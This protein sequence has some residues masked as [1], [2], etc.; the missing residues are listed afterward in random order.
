MLKNLYKFY[1]SYGVGIFFSSTILIILL[2]L[3]FNKQT[4][5]K[6]VGLFFLSVFL[7]LWEGFHG[8]APGGRY[9]LPIV[10]TFLT[11]LNSGFNYLFKNF[12]RFKNRSISVIILL[13]LI[14]NL[15]VLE[16]RNTNLTSYLNQSV[17]KEV[18]INKLVI[19]NNKIIKENTP[20]E[21]ITYNH[22]IFSNMIF[23][24]KLSGSD[25][26]TFNNQ[27]LELSSIYPMTGIARVIYIGNNKLDIYGKKINEFS[28]KFKIILSFLYSLIASTYILMIIFCYYNLI[29]LIKKK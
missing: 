4:K 11:E 16:Y 5:Y 12:D 17:K 6:I 1:F 26:I 23:F 7:C 24:N 3:G 13:L 20:I 8:Y 19:K 18:V 2:V 22:L 25:N 21:K 28:N 15:P 9:F 29:S 14:F 27:K 10:V